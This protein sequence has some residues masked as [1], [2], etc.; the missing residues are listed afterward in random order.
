MHPKFDKLFYILL[1]LIFAILLVIYVNGQHDTNIT[2]QSAANENWNNTALTVGGFRG[3]VSTKKATIEVPLQLNGINTDDYYVSG[4]PDK[5][6]IKVQGS[7]ALVT[8]AQ[9]TQ[10]FQVYADLGKLNEGDHTVSLK[11][12]GL[13]TDL[14]YAI[15]PKQVKVTIVRRATAVHKVQINYNKDAIASGYKLDK[16]TASVNKVQ[17]TGRADAVNAV[18]RVIAD[19][20][21]ARD[22]KK[23]VNESVALQAVDING[24][25][26]KVGIAPEV[27]TVKLDIKAGSG[28]RQVPI[29]FVGE[30]GD[31]SGYTVS[32]NMNE[33]TV[34]GK[35]DQL[36]K[37]KSIKVP[38]NLKKLADGQET[39]L[40]LTTDVKDVTLATDKIKVTVTPKE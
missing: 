2:R 21:L 26:I 7:A 27:A 18:D 30:H 17:V 11:V 31:L 13:S 37:I 8:A 23:S 4:A 35:I 16:V 38:I 22:S 34:R 14:T 5:V 12:S 6:K 29:K 36:D 32:G 28:E 1:S 20:H 33:V 15:E 10:N 25:P 40:P 3:L 24:T 9:N 39:T 19:V